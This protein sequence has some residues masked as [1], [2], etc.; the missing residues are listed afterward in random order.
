MTQAARY[1][2][3]DGGKPPSEDE[4]PVKLYFSLAKDAGEK[5]PVLAREGESLL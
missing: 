4:N 1:F 5:I 3:A 2:H